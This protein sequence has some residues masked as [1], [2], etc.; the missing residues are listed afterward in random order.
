MTRLDKKEKAHADEP[1]M[2]SLSTP[3]LSYPSRQC[4]SC[5][6]AC[7]LHNTSIFARQAIEAAATGWAKLI[8]ES[9]TPPSEDAE[10]ETVPLVLGNLVQHVN[11]GK[12]GFKHTDFNAG[13]KVCHGL[14]LLTALVLICSRR[15]W[16]FEA[17]VPRHWRRWSQRV[18]GG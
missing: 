14:L 12:K 16:C 7:S 13:D 8:I 2:Q 15:W 3:S 11:V 18:Q 17:L 6:L 5:Q 10:T 9:Y 4:L 1:P